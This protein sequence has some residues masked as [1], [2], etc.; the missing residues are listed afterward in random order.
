MSINELFL[1]IEKIEKLLFDQN[2]LKKD[3][4]NIIEASNYL[5]IST[6]HLYKLTS[7]CSIPFYKPNGKKIYFNRKELDKWLLSN[8]QKSID[9]IENEVDDYLIKKGKIKL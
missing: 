8:R 7:T 3:V 2:L 1:K 6:S 9:E 5:D 4:L